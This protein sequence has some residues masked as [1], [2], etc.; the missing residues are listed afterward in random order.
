MKELSPRQRE[1]LAFIEKY[2]DEH[3]FPPSVGE[4]AHSS[5][6]APATAAGHVG[7]LR[8][9]GL[10]DRT[11]LARSIVL[12]PGYAAASPVVRIPIYSRISSPDIEEAHA[13]FE[14]YCTLHRSELGSLPETR[15]FALRVGDEAMRGLGIFRNDIAVLHPPQPPPRVGDVAAVIV[16]GEAVLRSFFPLADGVAELRPA[17]EDAAA[18]RFPST[19]LPLVGVLIAIQ[20]FYLR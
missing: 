2:L 19:A 13:G 6:I 20:R 12:T 3:G 15:L 14:G 9:K 17:H 11:A 18:V 16:D 7:A 8:R 5:G 1:V 4:I 10:L